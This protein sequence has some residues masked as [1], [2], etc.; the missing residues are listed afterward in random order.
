MANQKTIDI[1]KVA[2]LANIP[3]TT[4]EESKFQRQLSAVIDFVKQLSEVDTSD[5]KPTSQ[6]TGLENIT[7]ED[8][9]KTETHLSQMQATSGTDKIHNGYFV[10]PS[11]FAKEDKT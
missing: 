7:R 11:I 10:V 8:L 3:L 1:K 9:I 5:I 2:K 4:E 6:T